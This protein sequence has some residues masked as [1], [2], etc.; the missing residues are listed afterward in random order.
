MIKIKKHYYYDW[1]EFWEVVTKEWL[2]DYPDTDLSNS[3]YDLVST[4]ECNQGTLVTLDCL[5][6]VVTDDDPEFKNIEQEHGSEK[7]RF[8]RWLVSKGFNH[9]TA[10]RYWW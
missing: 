1:Y 4:E 9:D 5:E 2:K 6:D 8:M 3:T 10:L 7:Y